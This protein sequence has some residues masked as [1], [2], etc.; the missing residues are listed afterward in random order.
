M[1]KIPP[2]QVLIRNSLNR[3]RSSH[4]QRLLRLLFTNYLRLEEKIARNISLIDN[5]TFL[6]SKKRLQRFMDNEKCL[7]DII[8]T[9]FNYS[10]YWIY[11][12]IRSWQIPSEIKRLLKEVKK[13][14]SSI[15]LEI[16][17]FQ[18]GTL[19]LFTRF[20]ESHKIITI[21]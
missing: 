10:G 7:D 11:R 16:G 2:L 17:T 6:L 5:L 9:S 14:G 12:S 8:F 4:T 13:N 1:S 15:V 18:G 3:S 19:Y 20:F 21:D